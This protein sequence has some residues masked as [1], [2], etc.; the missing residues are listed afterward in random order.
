MNNQM[1]GRRGEKRF[2]LLC[3]DAGVTCNRSTEDDYGWDKLIEYPARALPFAAIDMQPGHIIAAVQVK[4]T[5]NASRSVSISLSNAL[6]Y[7]KSPLPQFIVLIVLDGG[8]VRYF[9]RHVWGP[10][11]AEWLK[12]GR[13]ADAEGVTATHKRTVNVT[14]APEDEQGEALLSWIRAEIEAIAPPYAGAKKFIVDTAGFE[15]GFGIAKVTFSLE[16]SD[17]FLDLQ[18]GLKPHLNAKR[19]VYTSERFGI[20]ASK[21]E[22]DEE[23]IQIFLKP[24]GR[25]C[26]LRLEFPSGG[27]VTVPATLFQAGDD[28]NF[29]LRVASRAIDVTLGPRGRVRA[30][31]RLLRTDRAKL[32]ELCA[33]FHLRATKPGAEVTIHLSVNGQVFDLGA[34]T[35]KG[36]AQGD[37]WPWIAL[38]MDVMRAIASDSGHPLGELTM[39]EIQDASGD[40]EILSALATDRVIRVDFTP[41]PDVPAKFDGFLAYSNTM[42]GGQ[43]FSAVAYRPIGLDEM[44]GERRRAIFGPAKL[45]WGQIARKDGWTDEAVKAAYQRQLDRRSD[46]AQIMAVGDLKMMVN[47]GPGDHELKSD[48]PTG[49]DRP[50]L[51][52]PSRKLL[53]ARRPRR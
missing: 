37:S 26:S 36:P 48:L 50:L 31:A 3:S 28:S 9:A 25:P 15:N 24:E 23:N 34:I 33:F 17:D 32:E 45:L 20:R 35:M 40:L 19:F 5:V 22:I 12:A 43:V 51:S 7:A 21:P 52:P 6:R 2:E 42:I 13:Q 18:L 29:A 11:I 41:E 8:G 1:I 49:R 4:T 14:F 46:D 44:D 16:S 38:G 27:S 30:H 10:L 47:R 39:G 53:R